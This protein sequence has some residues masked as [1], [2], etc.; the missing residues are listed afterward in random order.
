LD[1][2]AN[3]FFVAD[4]DHPTR[5]QEKQGALP[6]YTVFATKHEPKRRTPVSINLS[7][8]VFWKRWLSDHPNLPFHLPRLLLHQRH[9]PRFVRRCSVTQSLLPPLQL[10][11]WEQLPTTLASRRTGWRT[12]PLS[13]YIGAY[14]VKLDQQLPTFGRLHRFLRDHPALIWA[15]GFPLVPDRSQPHQFNIEASLPTQRHFCQRLKSLPNDIL[16]NLLDSQ[17][18]WLH[19]RF[20][21]T[22]GQVISWD[23][24]HILAW[25]SAPCHGVLYR[26]K[27]GCG[28]FARPARSPPL[29]VKETAL[30]T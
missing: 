21:D 20:G 14:L 17:V 22:F 6:W 16:Q 1:V 29:V 8:P 28:Q 19:C 4:G 27:R 25:V 9:Q 5:F 3:T 15:L 30:R 7:I 11:D 18:A 2:T 24:K 12:T 26:L 13:A 23:T 10:L